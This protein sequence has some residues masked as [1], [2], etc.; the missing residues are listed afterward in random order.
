M[1][2]NDSVKLSALNQDI[3]TL[4]GQNEM[5]SSEIAAYLN[6]IRP[7]Q[8]EPSS[9]YNVLFRLEDSGL[10]YCSYEESYHRNQKRRYYKITPDGQQIL[11]ETEIYRQ[12]LA[13]ESERLYFYSI[14]EEDSFYSDYTE[15]VTSLSSIQEDILTL[16]GSNQMSAPCI[17]EVVNQGRA[18]GLGRDS[19]NRVISILERDGLVYCSREEQYPY[20]QNPRCYM[21]TENGKAILLQV[22]QYRQQLALLSEQ[23]FAQHWNNL[24]DD[25]EQLFFEPEE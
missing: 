19:V 2:E 10:V 7:Q 11:Q 6:Q 20:H 18:K 14:P 3:L 13:D 15:E 17:Y 21:A 23:L 1:S 4:L 24:A 5:S 9:L 22:Q 8:M 16:L 25:P 12:C